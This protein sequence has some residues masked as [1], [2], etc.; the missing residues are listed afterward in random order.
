MASA[1]IR[2]PE[3]TREILRDLSRQ[4]GEPIS[5]LVAKAVE[6][7]RREYFLEATNRAFANLRED[8]EAWQEELAERA[9]WEQTL[10]DGQDEG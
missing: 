4:S 8:A 9:E 10:S 5:D 1:T 2:V 6:R 7:L 3:T